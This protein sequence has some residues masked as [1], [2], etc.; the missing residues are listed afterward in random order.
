MFRI[1]VRCLVPK[2]LVTAH[3]FRFQ[4]GLQHCKP[5][6]TWYSIFWYG[7]VAKAR[8]SNIRNSQFIE[9]RSCTISPSSKQQ[10]SEQHNLPSLE[11]DRE[12]YFVKKVKPLSDEQRERLRFLLREYVV[13][14]QLYIEKALEIGISKEIYPRALRLFRKH[15]LEAIGRKE[16][17]THEDVR[18]YNIVQKSLSQGKY[19]R[20]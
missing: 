16:L 15:V 6:S 19:K 17:Y 2:L 8:L 12:K 9:R 4:R 3:G 13:D 10:E 14:N 11:S 5:L 1:S 20:T 7:F 18:L